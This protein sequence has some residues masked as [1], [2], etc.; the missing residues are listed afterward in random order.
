MDSSR[1]RK[2][3]NEKVGREEGREM[4]RRKDS[5]MSPVV[6]ILCITVGVFWGAVDISVSE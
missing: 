6:L 4:R 2:G 5:W 1:R 3:E